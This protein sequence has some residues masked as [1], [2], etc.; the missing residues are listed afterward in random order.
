[1]HTSD[2]SATILHTL[3]IKHENFSFRFGGLDQRLTGVEHRKVVKAI[4]KG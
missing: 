3:G 1:V 4:L 2:L